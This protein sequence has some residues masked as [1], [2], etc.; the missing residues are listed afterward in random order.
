MTSTSTDAIL[1][2]LNVYSDGNRCMGQICVGVLTI[3]ESYSGDG[4]KKH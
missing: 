4:C 1:N 2:L 3:R